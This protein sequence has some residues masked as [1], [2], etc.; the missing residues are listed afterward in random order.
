MRRESHV[1]LDPEK[2]L[3]ALNQ[4]GMSAA[5]L[6]RAGGVSATTL[7]GLLHH[8]RSVSVRTA[9]RI[10]EGLTKTPIIKQLEELL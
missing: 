7:S 4:R 2:L 5:D 8:G 3:H 1:N 9:R 6:A 10:S